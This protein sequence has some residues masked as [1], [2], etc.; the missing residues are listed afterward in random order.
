MCMM[1]ILISLI[2]WLYAVRVI[3]K[4]NN[5]RNHRFNHKNLRFIPFSNSSPD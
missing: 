1:L 5:Q 2:Y 3:F 4:F